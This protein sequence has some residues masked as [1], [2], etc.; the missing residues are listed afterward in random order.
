MSEADCGWRALAAL[1]TFRA[2]IVRRRASGSVLGWIV[3]GLIDD[4]SRSVSRGQTASFRDH[5]YVDRCD[6]C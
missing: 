1:P 6:E 4:C 5:R 3:A 2:L